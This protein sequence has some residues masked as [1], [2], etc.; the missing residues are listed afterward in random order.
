M[1]SI[2]SIYIDINSCDWSRNEARSKQRGY[3]DTKLI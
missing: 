1:K 2:M 3:V